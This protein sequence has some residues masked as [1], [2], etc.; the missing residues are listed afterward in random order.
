[1]IGL[2]EIHDDASSLGTADD[3][4]N[5]VTSLVGNDG[6]VVVESQVA[7]FDRILRITP[8]APDAIAFD[9]M[10]GHEDDYVLPGYYGQVVVHAHKPRL[11]W[12]T[13]DDLTHGD[14]HRA[15][16]AVIDQ[17]VARGGRLHS[18][19]RVSRLLDQ[20]GNLISGPNDHGG[21]KPRKREMTFPSYR[22]SGATTLPPD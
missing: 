9:V 12:W 20:A 22:P 14:G 16:W 21:V 10:I 8:H 15:A 13:F 4:T 1:M 19:R 2:M 17:I 7:E 11:G 3:L 5:A 6:L 18:E